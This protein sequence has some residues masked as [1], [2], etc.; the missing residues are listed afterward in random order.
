MTL[1]VLSH[2][3]VE[4]VDHA[5]D[6]SVANCEVIRVSHPSPR[7]ASPLRLSLS[8][9]LLRSRKDKRYR[10]PTAGSSF[11]SSFLRSCLSFTSTLFSSPSLAS[12]GDAVLTPG[13]D[14][15]AMVRASTTIKSRSEKRIQAAGLSWRRM[16]AGQATT[17]PR[18]L[19]AGALY[20]P[21]QTGGRRRHIGP[22]HVITAYLS[23]VG[24]EYNNTGAPD[25]IRRVC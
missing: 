19:T 18:S 7:K 13:A 3:H 9:P 11:P 22:R 24:C 2:T 14:G 20:T 5:L 8:L 17:G 12:G 10:T 1:L 15:S 23:P 16:R 25:H 4:V 21:P 6:T